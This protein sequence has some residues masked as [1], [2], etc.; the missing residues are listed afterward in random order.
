MSPRVPSETRRTL[1]LKTP[2]VLAGPGS[3]AARLFARR[4]DVD[5]VRLAVF[6]DLPAALMD[7]TADGL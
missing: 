2:Y 5:A 3:E 1:L 6:V 7:L 4:E